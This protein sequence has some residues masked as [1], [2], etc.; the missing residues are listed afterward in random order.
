MGISNSIEIR[1]HFKSIKEWSWQRVQSI[2]RTYVHEEYDFG[3]DATAVMNLTSIPV[4]DA[5]AMVDSLA[6]N[7]SGIVNSITL[8]IVIICLA[9]SKQRLEA[10]RISAIF[11][12]V[13]FD[14]TNKIRKD[15]MTILK[16]CL[17]SAFCAILDRNEERPSDNQVSE[18]TSQMFKRMNKKE[19]AVITNKEFASFVADSFKDYGSTVDALFDYFITHSEQEEEEEVS[20]IPKFDVQKDIDSKAADS[21]ASSKDDD[22]DNGNRESNNNGGSKDEKSEEKVT[23]NSGAAD[24]K[25][26]K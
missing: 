19:N 8:L 15:E 12:L 24:G 5:K 26:E 6:R 16:L 13:D 21:K 9:D 20:I 17:S 14:E 2:I 4:I 3:L 18:L 22:N 11:S 10:E 25:E 1:D 23:S 7:D